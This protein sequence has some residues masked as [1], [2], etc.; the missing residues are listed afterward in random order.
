MFS[1]K[2]EQLETRKAGYF[3]FIALGCRNGEETGGGAYEKTTRANGGLISYVLVFKGNS[4]LG[5]SKQL[6]YP[7]TSR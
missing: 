2:R 1:L 4:E 5:Q 3:S 6:A 7:P